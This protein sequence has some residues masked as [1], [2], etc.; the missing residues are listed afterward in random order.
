MS[1]EGKRERYFA[2]FHG[3]K[4]GVLRSRASTKESTGLLGVCVE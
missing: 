4:E 2:G 3:A 1:H